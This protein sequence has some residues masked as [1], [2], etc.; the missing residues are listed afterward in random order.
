MGHR[1]CSLYFSELDNLK[2]F[3]DL[4]NVLPQ[5]AHFSDAGSFS[6]HMHILTRKREAL[7]V[8]G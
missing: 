5:A 2:A 1:R 8:R 7:G 4:V 6:P 3:F